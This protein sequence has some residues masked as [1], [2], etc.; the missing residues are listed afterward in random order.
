[1]SSEA[2][3]LRREV[4]EVRAL[5]ESLR[6]TVDSI[7]TRLAQLERGTSGYTRVS[8]SHQVAS[9]SGQSWTVVTDSGAAPSS[10]VAVDKED[11]PG[12]VLLAKR[13]GQFLR[14]CLDG[15]ARGSSGRELLNLPNRLYVVLAGY[16][17][18]V[19][20]EP[21]IFKDFSRVVAL[22]KQGYSFGDSIFVGFATQWE[23]KAAL[24]EAKLRW[25]TLQ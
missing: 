15:E 10:P 18:E 1:M 14:R 5:L 6:V 2:T 3:A 24:E 25:T 7:D 16:S 12:R 19:Y 23:A 21:K 11:H 4:V 13:I 8:D 9:E 20:S 22:C 17:G